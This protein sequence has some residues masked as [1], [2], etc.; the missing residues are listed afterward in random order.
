[1]KNILWFCLL[2]LFPLCLSGQALI[3]GTIYNLNGQALS[4]V[5]VSAIAQEPPQGTTSDTEG[6]F[7]LR[8]SAKELLISSV[9][10]QSQRILADTSQELIITLQIQVTA[11]PTILVESVVI[12]PLQSYLQNPSAVSLKKE[13]LIVNQQLS[14]APILNQIPGVLM[15]EGALNTNRITIRGI[16]NRSPFG[17]SKIRAT[18][19]NIPIHNGAGELS[20]EDFDLGILEQIEVFKGPSPSPLGANLGGHLALRTKDLPRTEAQSKDHTIISLNNSMGSF[21][22]IRNI[23]RLQHQR[24]QKNLVQLTLG[25]INADGYRANNKYTRL[26][27]TGLGKFQLS[28]KEKLTVLGIYNFSTAF[29]PSSLNR[30]DYLNTPEIAAPNWAEARG[31]ERSK[32]MTAGATYNVQFHSRFS[33]K[34]TF[35]TAYRDAYEKRPFNILTEIST[36]KGFRTEA[37]F[38]FRSPVF[39]SFVLQT[40]GEVYN[41]FYDWQTYEIDSTNSLGPIL[42]DNEENRTYGF[43][44]SQ[45]K[46]EWNDYFQLVAGASLNATY[47]SLKDRYLLDTIKQTAN[48]FFPL[49]IS[50]Y[51]RASWGIAQMKNWNHDDLSLYALISR[52]S[53][54]PTLE[55]TL[56]P[57]GKINRNIRPEQG[58]NFELGIKG[59]VYHERWSYQFSVY[60][61][62]IQ[63]LLVARRIEQDQFIGL[64]AGSTTHQGLELSISHQH[65]SHWLKGRYQFQVDYSYAD[66]QFIDFVDDQDDFSGNPLT[67]TAPHLIG[68]QAGFQKD[69]FRFHL[70][71]RFVDAMPLRDDNTISSEAF[72]LLNAKI[73]YDFSPFPKVQFSCYAG[74]N[75]I[76]DTQYASM[77]LVNASSFGGAAPRY[78]YPG[79]PINFYLGITVSLQTYTPPPP[80]PGQIQLME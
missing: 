22:A 66:Y 16:G 45:L 70:Q 60:R 54:A 51:L 23:G 21:G 15:H 34:S 49:L 30:N 5:N 69:A 67:G 25:N 59:A 35:F 24:N 27:F 11:A 4:G 31:F 61:M 80:P 39:N 8:T 65:Y 75:N 73:F 64:N 36:L 19:D 77:H 78:Y 63:D 58:W 62:Q 3:R 48:R 72:H 17:T 43:A 71:Y 55:E 53:A 20:L 29:I 37:E 38:R 56:L 47:Y 76:L 42:S 18:I 33:L 57:D 44:F 2:F 1:M 12:G 26:F 50:P 68:C 40:G 52:G 32:R 28:S 46:I 7:Q 10:Y 6:Y 79:M 14:Y 13:K 74:V 41:E 9:G